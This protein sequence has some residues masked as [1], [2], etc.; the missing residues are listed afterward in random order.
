MSFLADN[1]VGALPSA[2]ELVPSARPLVQSQG[3]ASPHKA[4][5]SAIS[6]NQK[7]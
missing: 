5:I 2:E 3:I 1:V 4:E 6:W 7:N